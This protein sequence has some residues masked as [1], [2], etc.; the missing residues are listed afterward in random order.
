MSPSRANAIV[1]AVGRPR[2]VRVVL[3][4]RRELRACRSRPRSSRR[5][6]TSRCARSRTRSSLR[7][8]TTRARSGRRAR[9]LSAIRPS[10][11]VRRRWS[12]PSGVHREDRVVAVARAD[13]GDVGARRSPPPQHPRAARHAA[14][15]ASTR[16]RSDRAR[17]ARSLVRE[18][19]DAEVP[20]LQVGVA[21]RASTRSSRPRSRPP[22]ITSWRSASAVATPRFCSIS[23]IA[24]P[25]SSSRLNVSMRPSMTAGA[26]PS[27]GS[28]M[29]RI[30]G[31]V[32]SARPMASICCSP[33]ESCA[34]PLR[35][36]SASRG[37][38]S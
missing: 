10:A 3:L 24:R 13:E 17:S 20:A 38:S 21:R 15:T 26:S 28:S 16:R 33:P 29:T 18:R 25:S 35:L 14:S 7:P 6:R 34:P 1:L 37:K 11:S 19:L 2:R 22:I 27:D 23:R 31:F 9:R 12:L 8:A 32:T 5:C 4:R 36:R 30:F